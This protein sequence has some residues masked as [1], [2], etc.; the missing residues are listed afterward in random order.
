MKYI[1]PTTVTTGMLVS[2]TRAEND[3]PAWSN[4]TTYTNTDHA[5]STTTHRIYK[6]AQNGNLNH[7]PTTDDGTWWTD[8]GPTNRWAMFDGVVGT[9]TSQATP[10]TVV[11][12]TGR[13]NELALLD[14]AGSSVVVSMV[15]A[16]GGSTVFNHTYPLPDKALVEDWFDYFFEP[17]IPTTTLIV[18]NLPVYSTARLTVSVVAPTTSECGTMVI[19]VPVEIGSTRAGATVGIIDYSRKETDVFGVTSVVERSFVKRYDVSVTVDNRRLDYV[20]ER[21][22]EVRATPCVWVGDN[23]GKYESLIAYGFYK[24]W[25][26]EIAYPNI[27]EARISIEGII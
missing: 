2:S 3:Y 23:N 26:V 25:D 6:S 20:T 4:V 24:S 1:K 15:D 13:I 19:G 14:L 16:P 8:V 18:P 22:A 11:I 17:I 9:I 10:L 7:D 12:D 5:I 21:L 27:S